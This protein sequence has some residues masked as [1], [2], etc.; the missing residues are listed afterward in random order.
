MKKISVVFFCALQMFAFGGLV[1][2]WGLDSVKTAA[3][4]GGSGGVTKA[5]V[6]NYFN[7]SKKADDLQQSSIESL[8]KMLLNKETKAGIERKKKAAEAIQDPKERQAAMNQ[9]IVDEQAE[10]AKIQDDKASEQKVA[11]LDENQKKLVGSATS[12]LFLFSVSKQVRC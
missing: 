9:V 12:N 6:T 8:G 7:L 5:D 4:G 1:Y 2:G 11:N 3:L 10:L